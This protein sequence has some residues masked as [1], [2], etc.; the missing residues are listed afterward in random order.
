M[1]NTKLVNPISSIEFID[2]EI[3]LIHPFRTSFGVENHKQ[4]IIIKITDS[5]GNLGWGETSVSTAPGYCYET[6][7]TA[8]HIQ[9]DFLLDEMTN[10]TAEDPQANILDIMDSFSKIRGHQ[11]AKAGI[12]SALWALVSMQKNISLG[13]L[14]G[15]TK[16]KI[17]TGV[18]IGIQTD[19]D[20]L[21][22]RIGSFLDLG[23]HRIKIKIEPGWDKQVLSR[24]RSEYGDILLMVDANSAYTLKESHLAVLK[25]L[26]RFEL[27]MIEQPLHHTDMLMH[28]KLQA[29]IETPVCLDESIHNLPDAQLSLEF[30]CCRIIN[31]KPGRVGG[32][33][34][35][36]EIGKM[37]GPGKVWCGGML[38][39]GIGR[40]HNLFLQSNDNF[41]IPGDTSGSSRYFQQDIISP[42]IVVDDKGYVEIP[43]GPSL[44][45]D[46]N[47]N[48]INKFTR[49]S[50]KTDFKY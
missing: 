43:T 42:Q 29:E 49:K 1:K 14:Y 21:I 7:K 47:Q 35:A 16:H 19:L 10:L 23:Y 30:D 3:P 46:I 44:G 37:G 27:M 31:I 50:V 25:S 13:S 26:D 9:Q 20:Y 39:I 36:L 18:S 40:I 45:V 15:A 32:Y 41:T 48:L 24:V 11:F 4:A 12:E 38:E 34:T 17:P 6:T 33:Y 8:W 22:K 2:F 5:E 28:K